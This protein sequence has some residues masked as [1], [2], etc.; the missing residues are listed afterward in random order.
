MFVWNIECSSESF[1]VLK[2]NYWSAG[3]FNKC[4]IHIFVMTVWLWPHLG[5]IPQTNRHLC[6]IINQQLSL[7]I[8]RRPSLSSLSYCN[9]SANYLTVN[10]YDF[11][12][13]SV[14]SKQKVL[15]TVPKIWLKKCQIVMWVGGYYEVMMCSKKQTNRINRDSYFIVKSTTHKV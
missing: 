6:S 8:L 2:M 4:R 5:S 14:E 11:L 1:L 12:K 3:C 9:L 13:P 10:I 15:H 7:V